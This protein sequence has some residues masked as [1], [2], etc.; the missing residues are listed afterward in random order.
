[1]TKPECNDSD[2]RIWDEQ[3]Q[4]KSCEDLFNEA[5]EPE[6]YTCPQCYTNEH[7]RII[8]HNDPD[9]NFH[10]VCLECDSPPYEYD[11]YD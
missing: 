10:Y 8:H 4:K 3:A 5:M 6:N 11:K 7:I 1:M 9:D 2:N